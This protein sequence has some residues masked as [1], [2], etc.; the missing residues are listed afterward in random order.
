MIYICL[1]RSLTWRSFLIAC[2]AQALTS[3]F[4]FLGARDL[5]IDCQRGLI[6]TQ[7]LYSRFTGFAADGG[8]VGEPK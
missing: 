6:I 3:T 2:V 5:Q 1:E 7:T 8:F 4:S